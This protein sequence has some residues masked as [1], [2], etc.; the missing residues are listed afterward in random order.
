MSSS[1]F[2]T[3]AF[4]AKTSF[5]EKWSS[6]LN[7]TLEYNGVGMQMVNKRYEGEIKRRGDVVHIQNIPDVGVTDYDP[8]TPMSYELL[9]TTDLQLLIDQAKMYAFRV[10]DITQALSSVEFAKGLLERARMG[11]DLERDTH[12]MNHF[13]DIPTGNLVNGGTTLELTKNNAYEV[14]VRIA[15]ILAGNNA[16][17]SWRNDIYEPGTMVKNAKPY[18]V[19]NPAVQGILLQSPQFIHPTN[20]GDSVLR[21]G[22]IGQIAGLDIL[23]S[24]NVRTTDNKVN[25]MA[26]INDAI[27]FA[28]SVTGSEKLRSEDFFA[29]LF[30]GLY[31]YGSKVLVPNGLAG[32]VVDVSAITG[33]IG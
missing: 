15:T 8:T 12:I 7:R 30:R 19:I 24:T 29:D 16:V 28:G 32:A 13:S 3:I 9:H 20:A 27:G 5:A 31:C 6:L 4:Q 25:I 1:A 10:E 23:V 26:G 18:C 2:N 11:I 22:S 17:Q 21:R 33:D 14:F